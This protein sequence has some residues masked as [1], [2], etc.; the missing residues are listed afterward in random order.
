MKRSKR[1]SPSLSRANK[2]A[3]ALIEALLKEMQRG[4]RDQTLLE[5][6]EWE[7]LFGN[8]QSV[9]VNLQK[10]VQALA[11]LPSE[12]DIQPSSETMKAEGERLSDEEMRMLTAWLE[13]G[14]RST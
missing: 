10:L 2:R 12:A 6:P 11:A 8:K 9:V 7:R 13:E 4:V 3:S 1:A 5:S 14:K